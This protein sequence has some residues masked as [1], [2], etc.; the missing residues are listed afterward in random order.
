MHC[1]KACWDIMKEQEYGRIVVTSSS[2][3]LYGN[4][5][6][7]N[8]GAAKMGVV[9]MMNTLAQEGAKYNVKINAL[10]PTAGTRMTEGLIEEKAF[11]LLTPETVTPAVLFLVSEDAPTRTIWPQVQ[12][13]SRWPKLLRLKGCGYPRP[14]RRPKALPRIGIKSRRAVS[15]HCRLVSSR[16]S[17]WWAKRPK[18]WGWI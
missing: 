7:T 6:Q 8:Y 3:G 13:A 14:I 1:T 5:G 17:K 15:A 18:D 11:A 4:F 12:A 10:A 2:S 16:A 9:G